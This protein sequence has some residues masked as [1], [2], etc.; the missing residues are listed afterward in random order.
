MSCK[1]H[2]GADMTTIRGT[3]IVHCVGC[4][5]E[6]VF[7]HH[8]DHGTSKPDE[9]C[10]CCGI[11]AAEARRSWPPEK[12]LPPWLRRAPGTSPRESP[13]A[14]AQAEAEEMSRRIDRRVMWSRIYGTAFAV[15]MTAV[16]AKDDGDALDDERVVRH[17]RAM[18]ERIANAGVGDE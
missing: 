18:A 2:P 11:D 10:P 13:Q 9:W 8:A 17:V 12:E 4:L 3:S 5:R 16:L 6:T 1:N 14:P 15:L 7:N